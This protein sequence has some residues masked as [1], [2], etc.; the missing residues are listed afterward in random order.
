[1]LNSISAGVPPQTRP[2]YRSCQRSPNPLAGFAGRGRGLSRRRKEEGKVLGF[3]FPY[4]LGV[5]CHWMVS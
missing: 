2:H 5:R 3:S 4:L 1:V